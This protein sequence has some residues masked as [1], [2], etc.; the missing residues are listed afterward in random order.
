MHFINTW[1]Q[2]KVLFGTDFP[3]IDPERATREIAALGIRPE[4]LN[5]L[6]RENALRLYGLDIGSRAP[7]QVASGPK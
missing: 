4:A 5:K 1:G 7:A 6:L 3:V 2:D